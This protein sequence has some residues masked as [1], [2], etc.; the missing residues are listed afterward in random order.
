MRVQVR[1]EAIIDMRSDPGMLFFMI[2]LC[3]S[4]TA[5]SVLRSNNPCFEYPFK[6][7][8]QFMSD[9]RVMLALYH[10]L[11]LLPLILGFIAL[12]DNTL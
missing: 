12:R 10:L 4:R 8:L 9:P 6:E 1:F 7:L 11:P 2:S 3:I 5:A